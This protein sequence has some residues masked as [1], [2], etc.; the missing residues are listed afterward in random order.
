MLHDHDMPL[1]LALCIAGAFVSAVGTCATA[2]I[3]AIHDLAVI[4]PDE[5]AIQPLHV[6]LIGF[7]IALATF[8]VLILRAVWGRGIDTVNRFSDAQERLTAKM[9][10]LCQ[11]QTRRVEKLEE[12]SLSALRDA[13]QGK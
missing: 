7:I 1:Q 6:V 12:I 5:L 2:I 10:E 9:E 11:L 3:G 8:I 4:E 13:T